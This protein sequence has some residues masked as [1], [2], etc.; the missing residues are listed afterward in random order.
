MP[1]PPTSAVRPP[2]PPA[3]GQ[4]GIAAPPVRPASPKKETARINLP[5]DASKGAPALP[6]ATVKMQ[7]TQPLSKA[8]APAISQAMTTMSVDSSP[9]KADTASTVLSVLAFLVSGAAL[10]FAYQ[11][12]TAAQPM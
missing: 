1:P 4:S 9:A 2:A 12:F 11:V 10:F 7:Q 5:S 6:K 8:P 3:P